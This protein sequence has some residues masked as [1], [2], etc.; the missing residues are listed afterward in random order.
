M[1][2]K[3]VLICLGAVYLAAIVIATVLLSRMFWRRWR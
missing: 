3:I 1:D 2:E